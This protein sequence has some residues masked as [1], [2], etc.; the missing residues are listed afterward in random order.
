MEKEYY[1]AQV[2]YINEIRSIRHDIQAHMIVLQY[3]LESENFEKAK[4]YL[5]D[6]KQHQNIDRIVVQDTGHDLV[7]AIISDTLSR[8]SKKIEFQLKGMLPADFGMAEYDVCTLFS[9]LFS[10]AR[11]ACEK[12][13][14]KEPVIVMEVQEN[15]QDCMIV[16]QNPIEWKLET[17]GTGFGTSKKEKEAHGFGLKNIMK[18]VKQYNG[19]I[20]FLVTDQSFRVEI[21]LENKK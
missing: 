9:N 2:K 6:M 18:V 10:N 15:K 20:D 3:Y 19:K 17:D 4:A 1:D 14:E 5:Y 12:L 21:I 16:L 13:V 7:N 11:E 8:S